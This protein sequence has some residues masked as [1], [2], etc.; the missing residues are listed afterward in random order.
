MPLIN[1]QKQLHELCNNINNHKIIAIDIEFIRENTYLPILC[2]IQINVAQSCYAI[3]ALSLINLSPLFRILNNSKIIKIFHSARQDLEVLI[4]NFPNKIKPKSIFDTQIMSA[5]CGLGFNISYSN[6]TKDL[7]NK[8][9]SKDLQRSDW[10]QRPLAIEQIE[11]AKIDV[12]YLPEIYQILKNKLKK[13]RKIAWIKE[14]IKLMI[15]KANDNNLS[16]NFSFINKSLNYQKNIDLLVEWRDILAK[17]NNV[18]RSFV[19]KDD[20]LKKI[21]IFNS[22]Q[23]DQLQKCDFKTR[24]TNIDIKSQII[25]LMLDSKQINLPKQNTKSQIVFY[26]NEAQKEIY[27]KS[28]IL[29]QKKAKKYQLNSQLIINQTNLINIIC[30]YKFVADFLSGWRYKVFGQELELLILTINNPPKDNQL[31]TKD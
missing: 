12:L 19:I 20:L 10:Q 4:G 25:N 3:D 21:A 24:V 2:L 27:Q 1:S 30:G 8:E 28:K 13:S 17:Q 11:Y 15:I 22:T 16:R 29:L 6:L 14:E 23:A 7:L 18:P 26:L 9:V 31:I 5:L